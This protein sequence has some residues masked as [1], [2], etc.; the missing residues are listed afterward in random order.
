MITLANGETYAVYRCLIS[1]MF[2]WLHIE[3][4]RVS[5]ADVE[6]AVSDPAALETIVYENGEYRMTYTG[7]TEVQRIEE[8]EIGIKAVLMIPEETANE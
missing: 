6:R 7:Y 5:L 3:F 2:G 8:T 4:I 1:P